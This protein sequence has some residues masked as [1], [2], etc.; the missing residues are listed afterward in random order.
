[1]VNDKRYLRRL[2]H[3]S[4]MV[5]A[6]LVVLA[7]CAATPEA[8]R[9]GLED[10]PDVA[11]VRAAPAQYQD[12]AVRWGGVIVSVDNQPDYSMV[13]VVARPLSDVGRPRD[14][15]ETPGRFLARI[16]GFVDP[17]VYAQ[18]RELTVVGHIDGVLE[19]TI[20]EYRYSYPVVRATG[21]YL[22]Q[23]R[24]PPEPDPFF[25]HPYYSP[26]YDPWFPYRRYPYYPYW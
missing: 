15:D 11:M 16:S 20:G 23:V 21:H 25:Y 19:R 13:E 1:M 5:L 24:M 8:I 12:L 26:F 17:A 10:S 7:G 18:G 6:T 9:N 3:V 2:G 4:S 14:T 22:W